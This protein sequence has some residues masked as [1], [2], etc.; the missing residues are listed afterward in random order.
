[1][2]QQQ[3]PQDD[4]EPAGSAASI[5][6]WGE[7]KDAQFWRER[8]EGLR[9]RAAQLTDGGGRLVMLQIAETYEALAR[10]PEG[11]GSAMEKDE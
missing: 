4:S 10:R 9:A 2:Q 3:Q 11:R 1:V 8:A 5:D 6:S 7:R